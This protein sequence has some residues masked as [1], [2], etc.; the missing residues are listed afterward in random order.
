M[1]PGPRILDRPSWSEPSLNI[2]ILPKELWIETFGKVITPP[3][4]HPSAIGKEFLENGPYFTVMHVFWIANVGAQP[5]VVEDI[6]VTLRTPGWR[7]IPPYHL[8]L[9][10]TVNKLTGKYSKRVP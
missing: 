10:S 6:R 1:L 5:I 3:I 2:L 4:D 7:V 8:Y 9:I